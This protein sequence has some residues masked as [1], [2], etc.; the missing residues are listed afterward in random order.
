M[1]GIYNYTVILTYLGMLSGFAGILCSMSGGGNRALICLAAAGV[2][3]MFDGKVASTM[4][5]TKREKR[6]GVQI[7]SL[8]DLICFGVLP[9]VIVSQSCGGLA[10]LA[11]AVYVLAALI[12]LAWFNVDEE[13]R[14]DRET[15]RRKTYL[16][17]PVTTAAILFP[18][19]IGAGQAL[20][21]PQHIISPALLLVMA[22]AFLTPFRVKKPSLTGNRKKSPDTERSGIGKEGKRKGQNGNDPVIRLL[23]GTALGRTVLKLIQALHADRLIVRFLR[24]PKSRPCIAWYAKRHHIA[25]TGAERRQYRSFREFFARE[26][27]SA[28]FDVT[29]EHLISPC[30]GWLSTYPITEKSVFSIKESRY[31]VQDLLEDEDLA[32]DYEGGTCMVFRLCASDYHHYCYIDDGY[33]GAN[34]FIPGKLHSVQPIACE[35]YPVFTLNRRS[36]CLMATE[37]FGPVVQTEIGALVV[38]GIANLRENTRVCR[39]SEKGHFELAGSSIVLLFQKDRVRLLPELEDILRS[40][41]EARV[42]QGMWIA[43]SETGRLS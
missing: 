41:R 9:A 16:G 4:E 10:N 5:R 8:S 24:S 15:G 28:A 21:W 14:Q 34:H 36:W 22:A 32:K 17:L 3:D 38:G 35:T 23:Y 37:Q 27:E 31:R 42:L 30:D 43:S 26:R 18:A 20:G 7:D 40:G 33:Q 12:R 25:L 6:F 1:L 13:E 29:P 11:A 19:V 2:C 39:G